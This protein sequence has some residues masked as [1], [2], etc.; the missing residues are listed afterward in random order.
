MNIGACCWSLWRGCSCLVWFGFLFCFLSPR[1]WY[2]ALTGLRFVAPLLLSPQPW[3]DRHGSLFISGG[4]PLERYGQPEGFSTV[5]LTRKT[6]GI[7][8]TRMQMSQTE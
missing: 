7:V 8:M 2:V 5:N 6:D 4:L 3:D 1:S